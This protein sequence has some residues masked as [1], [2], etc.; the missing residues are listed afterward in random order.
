MNINASVGNT[1]KS[2][3]K[4][5]EFDDWTVATLCLVKNVICELNEELGCSAIAACNAS[6]PV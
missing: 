6:L 3:G 5:R 2:R 4:I 1:R